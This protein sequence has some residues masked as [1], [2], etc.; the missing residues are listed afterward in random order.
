MPQSR[1]V[2][3]KQP[4]KPP[5]RASLLSLPPEL[6]NSIYHLVADEI[7][8]ANI[9][10][11][12][13]GFG[14]ASPENRFWDTIAKHP[15]GQTSRQ[16]RQ[17]FGS[18]HR[19][20]VMT[21][22]VPRYNLL[23]ENYDLDRLASLARL[24]RQLPSMV[25]HLRSSIRNHQMEIKF[26][27]NQKVE[28]SVQQLRSHTEELDHLE[29]GPR[30]FGSLFPDIPYSIR[31]I[32]FGYAE[33]I[34]NLRNNAMSTTQ[35]RTAISGEQN[36]N[37]KRALKVLVHDLDRRFNTPE[38]RERAGRDVVAWLSRCHNQAHTDDL[39]DKRYAREERANARLRDHLKE[40][41]RAEIETELKAKIRAEV[42]D[43]VREKLKR[44]FSG[45]GDRKRT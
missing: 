11:R 34:L 22:G 18:V 12:K 2:P 40:E 8:E 6:R 39:R 30:M 44:E 5:S 3:S 9:V 38:M 24:L 13:I 7:D 14:A 43:E 41:L 15:L 4:T 32:P 25:P 17:E 31:Y 28:A 21:T 35:K 26:C 20:L 45:D 19:Y 10:G 29:N 36:L 33:V 1:K 23:L 16:L 37:V 27:L 42:E